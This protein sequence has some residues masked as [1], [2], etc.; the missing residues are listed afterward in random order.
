MVQSPRVFKAARPHDGPRDSAPSLQVFKAGKLAF[1]SEE[2][3]LKPL[4]HLFFTKP[5]LLRG[6]SVYDKVVGEAAARIFI[7]AKVAKVHAGTASKRAL[8][9]LHHA[10]ILVMAAREVEIICNAKHSAMCPMEKLS[11]EHAEDKKF[12]EALKKKFA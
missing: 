12:V 10:G 3:G 2:A 11:G 4:A 6:S 9:R 5:S 7:L 8:E 1:S